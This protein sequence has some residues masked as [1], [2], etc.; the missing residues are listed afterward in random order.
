MYA[1]AVQSSRTAAILGRPRDLCRPNSDLP[2]FGNMN[3]QVGNSRLG[4]R[5][6]ISGGLVERGLDLG[7]AGKNADFVLFAAGS[8]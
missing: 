1:G 4:W 5:Q 8:S 2:E 6:S 7:N 3:L